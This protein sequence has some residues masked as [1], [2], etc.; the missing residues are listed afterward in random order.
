MDYIGKQLKE[1]RISKG[2][3]I[4]DIQDATKIRTRYIQAIEEGNLEKLPGKFYEKAFIKS[5]SELVDLDLA[6]YN[7]YLES[8]P[9]ENTDDVKIVDNYYNKESFFSKVVKWLS[10]SLVYILI[11]LVI[12]IIYIFIGFYSDN[13]ENSQGDIIGNTR[14][15]YQSGEEG[16]NEPS[17]EEQQ[18]PVDN[19]NEITDQ[20]TITKTETST[21]ESRI[22][23]KYEVVYKKDADL[24]MNLKISGPC[25]I[26][27]N[28]EGPEGKLVLMKTL[29]QGDVVEEIKLDKTMWIH[30][31]NALNLDILIND[32]VINLGNEE[33]V[34]FV[35][36]ELK[37]IE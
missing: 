10:K 15:D 32:E 5:Y 31:G 22:L 8:L 28:E 11:I 29:H 25:W 12:F 21:Y 3:S 17:S 20:L 24:T 26:S 18:P 30:V 6:V 2:L 9:N 27:I 36:F 7:E 35:S 13:G 19:E 1:L 16:N 37:E 23:E 14:P 34:K 4:E 33:V